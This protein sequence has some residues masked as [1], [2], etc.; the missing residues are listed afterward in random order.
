[1]S[2]LAK[3]SVI[4]VAVS[5][6]GEGVDPETLGLTFHHQA[7]TNLFDPDCGAGNDLPSPRRSVFSQCFVQFSVVT[8]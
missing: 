5:V 2:K 8:I 7:A 6:H 1:M 3:N 4:V